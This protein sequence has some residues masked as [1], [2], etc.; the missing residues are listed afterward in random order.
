MKA[1]LRWVIIAVA[2]SGT[3]RAAE[4]QDDPLVRERC[5][6]A[7]YPMS[8][9]AI[10]APYREQNHGEPRSKALGIAGVVTALAGTAV[11]GPWGNQYNIF[12]E[13]VCVTKVSINSGPCLARGKQALIGA[14]MLGG[15]IL[16]AWQGFKRVKI[17]PAVS[18]SLVGV[19]ANV[20][21]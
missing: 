16:M 17:A 1:V 4:A 15:G 11:L 10:C 5:L 18:E 7:T 12:G 9:W 8:E 21:W 20:V 19:T 3:V 2:L 14:G 13:S 6:Q